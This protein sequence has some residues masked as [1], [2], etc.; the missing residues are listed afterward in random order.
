M[1]QVDTKLEKCIRNEFTDAKS[2]LLQ[3]SAGYLEAA[4][5]ILELVN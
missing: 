2:N 5:K 1:S 3:A 4:K